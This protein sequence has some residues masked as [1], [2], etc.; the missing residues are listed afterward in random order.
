M[1]D[2]PNAAIAR[3]ALEAFIRG[4]VPTMAATLAD[5]VVWHAPGANRFSGTFTGKEETVARLGAMREAGVVVSFEIHDV[6]GNDDHVVALVDATITN[7][8]GASC[9]GPQA[10]VMHVRDGRLVE[11]WGMNQDQAAVDRVIDG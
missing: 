1:S 4:D 3:G 6:V 7:A 11:F 10:Q 5:D 9:R 8:A 2:H